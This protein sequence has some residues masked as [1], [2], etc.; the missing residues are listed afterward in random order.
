MNHSHSDEITYTQL[1]DN[2]RL[3]AALVLD[4]VNG[5]AGPSVHALLREPASLQR[6]YD[7][8]A[9]GKAEL[10]A[11][12]GEL[13]TETARQR[14]AL[15]EQAIREELAHS[16]PAHRKCLQDALDA[17]T[18]RLDDRIARLEQALREVLALPCLLADDV[19]IIELSA[20][21]RARAALDAETS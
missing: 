5:R 6:W 1:P 4:D 10:E 9:T 17:E 7:T 13:R 19:D 16:S 18:H 2:Q 14:L 20:C 8:L 15:L 11:K 21:E 3:V 12:L